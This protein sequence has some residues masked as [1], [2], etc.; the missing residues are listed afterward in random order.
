VSELVHSERHNLN[1]LLLVILTGK[2]K[3]FPVYAIKAYG[4]MQV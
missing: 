2:A 4:E 1:I 3:V